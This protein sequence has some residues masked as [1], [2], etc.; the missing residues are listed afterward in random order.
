M[1]LRARFVI[2]ALALVAP[3]VVA[4]GVAGAQSAIPVPQ[5]WT[6]RIVAPEGVDPGLAA[7]TFELRIFSASTDAELARLAETLKAEGQLALRDAMFRLEAKGWIRIGK[8]AATELV[9]IRVGDTADGKRIARVY[10]DRALRL[11]DKTDPLGSTAHPFAF[12]ELQADS[13][14]TGTGVIIASASLAL[15]EEGLKIESA[16]TPV[17]QVIE[18]TTDTP[19]PPPAPR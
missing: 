8:R 11:Y 15:G 5:V 1:F 17:I 7:D 3:A 6:G 13:S 19:P 12:L 9:V 14:G 16:G 10:S 18:V 4:V 2:R